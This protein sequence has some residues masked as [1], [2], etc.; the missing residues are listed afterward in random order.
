MARQPHPSMN[1]IV[2]DPQGLQ[3]VDGQ[4]ASQV[5]LEAEGL[6]LVINYDDVKGGFS[7]QAH[8]SRC[9]AVRVSIIPQASNSFIVTNAD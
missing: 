1:I 3:R 8:S 6:V 5:T 9:C 4:T 2:R 7:V